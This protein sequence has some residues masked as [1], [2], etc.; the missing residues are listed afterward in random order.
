MKN[1]FRPQLEILENRLA[2]ALITW[3][4]GW[5]DPILP[6]TEPRNWHQPGNWLPA[7]EPGPADD[8]VIPGLGAS[9]QYV[10]ILTEP[11]TVRSLHSGGMA[12]G[13]EPPEVVLR[14]ELTLDGG[15]S[16]WRGAAIRNH[17]PLLGTYPE[18]RLTIEGGAEF[19][20]YSGEIALSYL[21]LSGNSTLNVFQAAGPL[22]G[23]LEVGLAGEGALVNL[24][25]ADA[26]YEMWGDLVCECNID[27]HDL[28]V[29]SFNEASD[30][31]LAGGIAWDN[32]ATYDGN[33]IWIAPGGTLRRVGR[34][35]P[36]GT[37]PYVELPIDN[38]GTVVL[39]YGT[40]L[41]IGEGFGAPL[42]SPFNNQGFLILHD[43][44]HLDV[45]GG[46][47]VGYEG[48]IL[49]VGGRS[50]VVGNID[51]YGGTVLLGV[52]GEIA[53]LRVQGRIGDT[54][55]NV[56]VLGTGFQLVTTAGTVDGMAG[57]SGLL[58]IDGTFTIDPG[59]G[60]TLDLTV[61]GQ[62]P[63]PLARWRVLQADGGRFGTFSTVAVHGWALAI[64]YG[65]I[66][67]DFW[68]DQP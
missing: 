47:A 17:S 26:L 52:P 21:T 40:E 5:Q 49:A 19:S 42:P 48:T 59:V 24:S 46:L 66:Y 8:V 31:F 11:R 45:P 2:P 37:G 62:Q 32:D 30:P 13:D 9:T 27:V 67:V 51:F 12:P 16:H 34:G 35:V 55:G 54:P 10:P 65:D 29:L 22:R 43:Q 61:L 7:T 41:W 25:S 33:S 56:R 23:T 36:L 60:A 58:Q 68:R 50:T 57:F 14:A 44:A 4:G 63:T 6:I 1:R 28:G 18:G 20:W 53:E 3:Q 39:E 64:D 38:L 15:S